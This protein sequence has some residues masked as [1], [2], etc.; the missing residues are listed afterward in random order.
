[1][2]PMSHTEPVTGAAT[3]PPHPGEHPRLLPAAEGMRYSEL[4]LDIHPT[5]NGPIVV[6]HEATLDRV[7]ED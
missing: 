3:K 1:M 2:A 7:T 5:A 6:V 4:E